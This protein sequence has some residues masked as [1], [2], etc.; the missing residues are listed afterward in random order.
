MKSYP[1]TSQSE[2]DRIEDRQLAESYNRVG[3]GD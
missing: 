1:H 2:R 3:T